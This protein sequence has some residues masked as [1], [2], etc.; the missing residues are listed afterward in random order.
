MVIA[1]LVMA[2]SLGPWPSSWSAPE[3]EDPRSWPSCSSSLVSRGRRDWSSTGQRPTS[4]SRW[5]ISL[6]VECSYPLSQRRHPLIPAPPLRG[7]AECALE[8]LTLLQTLLSSVSRSR[9]F[10]S[11]WVRLSFDPVSALHA[12]GLQAKDFTST[13][14]PLGF[15]DPPR[16][17]TRASWRGAVRGDFV[18]RC[19]TAR[20]AR[21]R[22]SSGCR[23]RWLLAGTAMLSD[24]RPRVP[25]RRHRRVRDGSVDQR[26]H[27]ADGCCGQ[28]T[29]DA[30]LLGMGYRHH[31]LSRLF[32]GNAVTVLARDH[33]RVSGRWIITLPY[34]HAVGSARSNF[35]R[36]RI[37]REKLGMNVGPTG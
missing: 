15:N 2:A 13:A 21:P 34:P 32:M 20:R 23:P 37:F 17:I 36:W 10:C 18:D 31:L 33:D 29:R 28:A 6:F 1:M 22:C 30:R 4:T 16:A 3:R 12:D 35:V 24:A 7:A 14:D 26:V 8:C 11:G 5:P 9:P 25:P 19:S 27:R